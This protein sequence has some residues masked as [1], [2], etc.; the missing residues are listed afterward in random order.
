LVE[1]GLADGTARAVHFQLYSD[2]AELRLGAHES[3]VNPLLV[4]SDL[5]ISQGHLVDPAQPQQSEQRRS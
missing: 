5:G 1:H 4:P 3:Q 2:N